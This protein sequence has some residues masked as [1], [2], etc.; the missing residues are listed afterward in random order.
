MRERRMTT[1]RNVL[2]LLGV[3]MT[4]GLVSGVVALGSNYLP[5][6]TASSWKVGSRLILTL[7]TWLPFVPI[8]VG[9]GFLV[10]RMVMSLNRT[11]WAIVLAVLLAWQ[12]LVSS[13]YGWQWLRM[14]W[15]DQ[16]GVPLTA[17]IIGLAVLLGHWWSERMQRMEA[18]GEAA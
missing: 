5:R 15:E 7:I 13:G 9:A 1:A 18:S 17:V 8:A 11:R 4:Y 12:T 6:Y 16:V 10:G 14:D 3:W 2:I